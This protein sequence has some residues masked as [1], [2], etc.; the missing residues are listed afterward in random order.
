VLSTCRHFA[1]GYQQ[2]YAKVQLAR[3]RASSRRGGL[4]K[5]P[6]CKGRIMLGEPLQ[7]QELLAH[8]DQVTPG[9]EGAADAL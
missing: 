5:L 4:R 1:I 6:L 2:I 3:T 8:H 9:Q 7:G